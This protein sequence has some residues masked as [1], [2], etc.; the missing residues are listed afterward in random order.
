MDS[1]DVESLLP[2]I[3]LP[4]STTV[5]IG[6]I[7]PKLEMCACRFCGFVNWFSFYFRV[8][9]EGGRC[10]AAAVPGEPDEVAVVIGYH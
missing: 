3:L 10:S 9:P 8:A 5:K 7:L 2:A 4:R 1:T 6:T